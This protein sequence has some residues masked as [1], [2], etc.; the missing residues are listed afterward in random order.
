[1]LKFLILLFITAHNNIKKNKL[2]HNYYDFDRTVHYSGNQSLFKFL[3]ITNNSHNSPRIIDTEFNEFNISRLATKYGAYNR[4]FSNFTS[5][6]K[7]TKKKPKNKKINAQQFIRNLKK[8]KTIE[9]DDKPIIFFVSPE[10]MM[11]YRAYNKT[12]TESKNKRDNIT[13]HDKP[14]GN[15]NNKSLPKDWKNDEYYF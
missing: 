12:M 7:K 4:R 2:F 3:S 5:I 10:Q 14:H 1:M 15:N 13:Q 8:N 9:R 6:K 11:I